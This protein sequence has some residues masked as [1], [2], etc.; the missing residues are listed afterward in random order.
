MLGGLKQITTPTYL[1]LAKLIN[2]CTRKCYLN[3]KRQNDENHNYLAH[4]S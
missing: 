2:K 3:E 4:E 1:C